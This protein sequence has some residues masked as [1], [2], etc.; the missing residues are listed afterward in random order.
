MTRAAQN[1]D[2]I[3]AAGPDAGLAATAAACC[4]LPAVSITTPTRPGLT[5]VTSAETIAALFAAGVIADVLPFLAPAGV[6][7]TLASR[8]VPRMRLAEPAASEPWDPRDPRGQDT[9]GAA[10]RRTTVRSARN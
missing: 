9:N 8:T 6:A 3:V 2:L 5:E 7:G 1:A 10:G 4:G